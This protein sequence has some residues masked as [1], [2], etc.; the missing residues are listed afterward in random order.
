[1]RKALFVFDADNTLWDTDGVFRDAQIALLATLAEAGLLKEPEQQL[2]ELRR[3]D[4]HLIEQTG[5]PEYDFHLLASALVHRYARHLT[6]QLAAET[7]LRDDLGGYTTLVERAYR[8]QEEVLMR[9]PHLYSDTKPVLSCMQEAAL[10]VVLVLSE[11]SPERL[12]RIEAAHGLLRERLIHNF[13]VSS[14]SKEAFDLA[15]AA[16]LKL[17][18]IDNPYLLIAVGDSMRREI[19]YGKQAGFITVYKPSPYRGLEEPRAPDE[20][21]DFTIER[22]RQ[23]PAVLQQLGLRL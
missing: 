10:G 5:R 21:P 22:L 20:R 4:Q 9:I 7:A 14:K 3:V 12:E 17:L 8:A 15:R 18:G 16:G 23:L 2:A 13:T 19:K 6:P 1:M 11:G